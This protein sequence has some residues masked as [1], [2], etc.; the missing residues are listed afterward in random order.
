MFRKSLIAVVGM[1]LIGAASAAERPSQ[2]AKLSPRAGDVAALIEAKDYAKA[3]AEAE[4]LAAAKD[5]AGLTFL[6]YLEERG[7]GG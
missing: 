1:A 3:R 4:A 2:P 6:G 5:P 7:L